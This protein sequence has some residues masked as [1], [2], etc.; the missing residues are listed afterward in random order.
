MG[1]SRV[2]TL[3]EHAAQNAAA[4]RLHNRQ[5]PLVSLRQ[6]GVYGVAAEA[7]KCRDD[8]DVI[9]DR[10]APAATSCRAAS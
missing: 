3:T 7:G 4:V 6:H 2:F 5:T 1:L 8:V 10:R 9:G